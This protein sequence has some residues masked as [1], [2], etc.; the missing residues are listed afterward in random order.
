MRILFLAVLVALFS[1]CAISEELRQRRAD[2]WERNGEE[3]RAAKQAEQDRIEHQ[4]DGWTEDQVI[5]DFGA[6]DRIE[7][8]GSFKIYYYI[9]DEGISS[10]QKAA[11]YGYVASGKSSSIHHFEQTNFF[12][13][14]GRVDHWD[15]KK[16]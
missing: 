1:G 10:K 4:Y 9:N 12:F 16:Q 5:R 13:K 11:A 8:A 15:F 2:T 14:D 6:P 7:N 3:E